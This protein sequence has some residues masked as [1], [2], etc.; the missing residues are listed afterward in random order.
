[1][2][3]SAPVAADHDRREREAYLVEDTRGDHRADQVRTTFG[4][5]PPPTALGEPGHEPDVV[6]GILAADE[7]VL[8]AEQRLRFVQSGRA[9]MRRARTVPRAASRSRGGTSPEFD[10][11]TRGSMAARPSSDRVVRQRSDTERAV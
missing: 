2:R 11:H 4:E 8:V 5:D 7:N 3:S 1:M 10:T 6:D 9:G